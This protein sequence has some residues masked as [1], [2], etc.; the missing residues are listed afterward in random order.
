MKK[1]FSLAAIAKKS[2]ARGK[3]MKNSTTIENTS[4]SSSSDEEDDSH[5]V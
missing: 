4:A 5:A 2:K 3:G 1:M